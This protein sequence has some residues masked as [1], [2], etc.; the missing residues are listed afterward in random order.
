MNVH[1][2]IKIKYVNSIM[3]NKQLQYIKNYLNT[4]K[5]QINIPLVISEKEIK[6]ESSIFHKINLHIQNC[7][8]NVAKN[9]LYK[10][11]P[12]ALQSQMNM[13]IERY[14]DFYNKYQIHYNTINHMLVESLESKYMDNM[15]KT[16]PC[17]HDKTGKTMR[18]NCWKCN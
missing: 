9:E 6:K 18:I 1:N 17:K 16:T 2:Y 8:F 14:E 4:H 3:S 15:L 7:D 5:S 11:S 10:L 12:P 13:K